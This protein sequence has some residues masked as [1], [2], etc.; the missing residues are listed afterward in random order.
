M[1]HPHQCLHLD[2]QQPILAKARV[3]DSDDNSASV[4]SGVMSSTR[5]RIEFDPPLKPG[6][7]ACLRLAAIIVF[8]RHFPSKLI[9]V[10]NDAP[11]QSCVVPPPQRTGGTEFYLK[12][13]TPMQGAAQ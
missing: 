8:P 4:P 9:V 10:F 6:M 1:S 7:R 5:T 12:N 11:P 3:L 2:Y 13:P